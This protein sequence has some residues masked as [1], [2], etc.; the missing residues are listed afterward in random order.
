M[1]RKFIGEKYFCGLDIGTHTIKAAL[2]EP[3]EN[4]QIELRGVYEFDT[5]GFQE[6]AVTNLGDLS[7]AIGEVLSGLSKNTGVR[8]RTL[9]LGL[10]GDVI[11]E[12]RSSAVIP[13]LDRGSKVISRRDVA[14]LQQQ[15]RFLGVKLDEVIL[16]DFPQVYTVDDI[17][18]T[19]NPLGLY[20]RK[21]EVETIVVAARS[22]MVRNLSKAV[23]QAGVDIENLFFTTYAATKTV[24]DDFQRKQGCAVVD[25]GSSRTDIVVFKGGQL[26]FLDSLPVGG[27]DI[28]R[29]IAD[30]LKITED[31]A[32]DMKKSYAVVDHGS[33]EKNEEILIKRDDGYMPV[34]KKVLSDAIEPIVSDL[35][36]M[37]RTS[38]ERSRFADELTAGMVMTGGGALLAGMGE[39]FELNMGMNVQIAKIR[40]S[41]RRMHNAAKFLSAV[42]LAHAGFDKNFGLFLKRNQ[43][44][45]S[46]KGA[47]NRVKELYEEYF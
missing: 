28:T 36:N 24:L 22:A 13:L 40:F 12:A 42:G 20:G 23:N 5:E 32:E 37:I 35:V 18:Q 25:I 17:N 44:S 34:Q 8:I 21:L 43:H 10:N 9:H 31:L 6:G 7:G 14:R 15:A 46:L 38:L 47:W 19:L 4:R 11:R 26:R 33:S 39:R 27:H 2:I 1:F 30:R 45:Q 41:S 3:R 16:H 29:A